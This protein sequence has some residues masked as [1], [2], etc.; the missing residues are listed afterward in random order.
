METSKLV[1][2][3]FVFLGICVKII[4][5]NQW[6]AGI[7]AIPKLNV[8]LSNTP[9]D[10]SLDIHTWNQCLLLC[11]HATT[12]KAFNYHV[13]SFRCELFVDVDCR[14]LDKSDGWKFGV[15]KTDNNSKT[16]VAVNKTTY[17]STI[18]SNGRSGRAVDG[19]TEG[20]Y[21]EESCT[22]T[23]EEMHPWWIVDLGKAYE[24]CKIV[25]WNRLDCCSDRLHDFAIE[26]SNELFDGENVN[27]TSWSREYLYT[28]T[29][30]NNPTTIAFP[31]TSVGRYIKIQNAID[32][33]IDALTLCEVEV[34][35]ES[36]D[37]ECALGKV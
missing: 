37:C 2:L 5:C 21:N 7:F 8:K 30:A 23:L 3:V 36:A 13:Y 29:P 33:S 17:Q 1:S 19:N 12:C 10:T 14:K 18:G 11:A 9:N 16:N 27:S 35:V 32:S 25:I 31:Q 4:A 6:T 26:V 22:H 34:Y 20:I 15:I 28:G 24:L